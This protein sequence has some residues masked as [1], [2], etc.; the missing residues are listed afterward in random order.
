MF[1]ACVTSL[2]KHQ[3]KKHARVSP[4]SADGSPVEL[5]CSTKC[6]EQTVPCAAWLLTGN[7]RGFVGIIGGTDL[8]AKAA[9]QV[10]PMQ[11][12]DPH[13]ATGSMTTD[14]HLRARRENSVHEGPQTDGTVCKLIDIMEL[15]QRE[16][17]THEEVEELKK[18]LV[19]TNASMQG[20]SL[21]L[22]TALSDSETL[23]NTRWCLQAATDRVRELEEG[24][25]DLRRQLVAAE[26]TIS[27]Q[28][29]LRGTLGKGL[30]PDRSYE[31]EQLEICSIGNLFSTISK[32]G[33][34]RLAGEPLTGRI[35]WAF[36]GVARLRRTAGRGACRTGFC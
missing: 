15:Q 5:L 32:L 25:S 4:L 8:T 24:A 18:L 30:A 33:C 17:Q 9:T 31:W 26:M 22:K 19:S 20:I 11:V 35:S 27:R 7:L 34:S 28:E 3:R 1:P 36:G 23:A 21:E 29:V 16:Q 14:V 6:F 2:R 12:P 10:L 13:T